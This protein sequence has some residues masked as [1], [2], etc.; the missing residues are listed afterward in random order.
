MVEKSSN[1]CF[2]ACQRHKIIQMPIGLLQLLGE[3][4]IVNGR[5][6][7]LHVHFSSSFVLSFKNDLPKL[8]HRAN[9]LLHRV[10]PR[11]HLIFSVW[12]LGNNTFDNVFNSKTK[13]ERLKDTSIR[14]PQFKTSRFWIYC[15][16]SSVDL[17]IKFFLGPESWLQ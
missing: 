2:Y 11:T 1:C 7:V 16:N 6:I 15:F 10:E 12:Q 8:C 5:L 9:P 14:F 17:F 13:N 3:S 4:Q